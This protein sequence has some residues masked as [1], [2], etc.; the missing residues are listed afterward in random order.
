MICMES[1]D[2]HA[3]KQRMST[4]SDK[5]SSV[6]WER[7]S[8]DREKGSER[9]RE[10]KEE[11]ARAGRRSRSKSLN[12]DSVAIAYHNAV[13]YRRNV[14]PWLRLRIRALAYMRETVVT[15]R[16]GLQAAGRSAGATRRVYA[17]APCGHLFVS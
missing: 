7:R 3:D 4:S 14:S 6:L 9:E 2:V 11:K 5:D 15:L 13:S 17:L 16:M 12:R 1:I 10:K 8:V